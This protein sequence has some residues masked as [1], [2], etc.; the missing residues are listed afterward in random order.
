M[1]GDEPMFQFRQPLVI[2]AGARAIRFKNRIVRSS[3]GGR[4]AYYDGTANNAWKNFEYHFAKSGIGGIISATMSV[5]PDRH[6]P[7]EYPQIDNDKFIGPL[8]EGVAA[9]KALDCLYIMQIGDCGYHTQT[10]LFSGP[11]ESQSSSSGFDLLY[12]FRNFRSEITKDEI[13]KEIEYFAKAAG[14]VKRIGCDGLEL[15]A[16]KGYLIHQF[17]NPGINRRRDEYGEDRFLLLEQ[18]VKTIQ[19]EVGSD[20]LLGVRLS[21]RDMNGRPWNLRWPPAGSGNT[22]EQSIQYGSRLKELG[23]HYLHVTNGFGF[24]CPNDNPGEFPLKEVTIFCDSTR[25]LS[26]KAAVRA[27]IMH[28]PLKYIVKL[29][30][31]HMEP[32]SKVPDTLE[33]KQRVGLPV[34]VNG[35]F[36]ERG[37]IE[38]AL[39]QGC[40]LVSIGR[41]LIANPNLYDILQQRDGPENPCSFCNKCDMRTSLFP[42]GCYDVKRFYGDYRKM[43]QQIIE[44]S[45]NPN[46]PHPQDCV[47]GVCVRTSRLPDAPIHS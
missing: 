7:L 19:S 13:N 38:R 10:S 45:G 24:I 46:W 20:Y 15:T 36:Q 33:L 9:V 42:L 27:A 12:G 5:N 22:L 17:L 25:H 2:Q 31:K 29:G 4:M 37:L 6:S 35:G 21:A 39:A 26:T 3:L 41:P 23:V 11:A 30:W 47:P 40:D 34:I 16:A 43:E 32:G 28:S 8:A 14:R 18:V 1:H 44:L